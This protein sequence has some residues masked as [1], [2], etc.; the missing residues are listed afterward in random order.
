MCRVSRPRDP[1]TPAL[2]RAARLRRPDSF[3]QRPHPRGVVLARQVGVDLRRS[4]G[5]VPEVAGDELQVAGEPV[6]FRAAR[7]PQGVNALPLDAGAATRQI[8]RCPSPGPSPQTLRAGRGV[9]R[10]FRLLPCRTVSAPAARS[11][12][13]HSR[14]AISATRRPQCAPRR[15]I[16]V[17][18]PRRGKG[19]I[20]P[21]RT[22][23]RR[24]IRW[25][26]DGVPPC[27]RMVLSMRPLQNTPRFVEP[28]YRALHARDAVRYADLH[29]EERPAVLDGEFACL[30]LARLGEGDRAEFLR[31]R[32][33]RRQVPPEGIAL[34]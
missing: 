2:P 23:V 28:A 22:R 26:P 20:R 7:V 12:S 27:S 11:R 29:I 4:G 3:P 30:A 31:A 18:A 24:A 19:S 9:A 33:L 16:A 5:A 32:P 8:M 15:T 1:P 13:A 14:P 21:V 25:G 34:A 6:E 10:R 17:R